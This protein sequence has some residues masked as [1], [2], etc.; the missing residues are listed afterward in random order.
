MTPTH[1]ILYLGTRWRN[2]KQSVTKLNESSWRMSILVHSPCSYFVLENDQISSM[3]VVGSDC[4]GAFSCG[5]S[6]QC[7]HRSCD[8]R[9][10]N[11]GIQRIGLFFYRWWSLLGISTENSHGV[12]TSSN[13]TPKKVWYAHLYFKITLFCI[14]SSV[15]MG[16]RKKSPIAVTNALGVLRLYCWI[17]NLCMT[18][19]VV[20]WWGISE[21][22][23][24]QVN[25]VFGNDL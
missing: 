12:I 2:V 20:R 19:L 21:P 3:I 9:C 23:A 10:H 5:W 7:E 13:Q 15:L 8:C 18:C 14:L 22:S 6:V 17:L 1:S 4:V 25:I 11:S 16:Q 24:N